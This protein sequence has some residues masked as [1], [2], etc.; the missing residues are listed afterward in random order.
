MRIFEDENERRKIVAYNA[1]DQNLIDRH[2]QWCLTSATASDKMIY[3]IFFLTNPE[4][5]SAYRSNRLENKFCIVYE[6]PANR[7]DNWILNFCKICYSNA[8][9][10]ERRGS[11]KMKPWDT[12]ISLE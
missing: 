2:H 4:E 7:D 5:I 11:F 8:F 9:T 12:K 6:L 3:L 10:E 1:L